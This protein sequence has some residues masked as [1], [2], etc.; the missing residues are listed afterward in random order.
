MREFRW[1]GG[2]RLEGKG[3]SDRTAFDTLQVLID[4]KEQKKNKLMISSLFSTAVAG[5]AH[6]ANTQTWYVN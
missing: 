5:K 3:G 6:N 4:W 2:P 1:M